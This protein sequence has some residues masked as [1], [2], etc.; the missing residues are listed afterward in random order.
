[1]KTKLCNRFWVLIHEV[2][3]VDITLN[4]LKSYRFTL[5]CNGGAN[6]PCGIRV[7]PLTNQFPIQRIKYF[8]G[9]FVKSEFLGWCMR[10][11]SREDLQNLISTLEN[12]K[13]NV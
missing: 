5:S 1:M 7:I 11:L 9:E 12:L 8:Q 3:D 10:R 4:G 2:K 13:P 6:F